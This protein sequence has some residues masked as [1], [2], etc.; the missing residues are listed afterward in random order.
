MEGKLLLFDLVTDPLEERDLA[1]QSE[2][3]LDTM[4]PLLPP[5]RARTGPL[6]H[7]AADLSER[8]RDAL[9]ELGYLE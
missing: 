7:P 6:Q 9:R 5:L 3:Q 2:E 8:D 4:A 1:S